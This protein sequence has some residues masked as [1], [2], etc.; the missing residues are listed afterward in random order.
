MNAATEEW[1]VR[2]EDDF[3]VAKREIKVQDEPSFSAVCFHAQQCTEK[4]LKA[5]L[6]ENKIPFVK[7]HD[8]VYLLELMLPLKPLWSVY[9]STL[10]T[11]STYAVDVRYPGEEV[12]KEEALKAVAL[13]AEIRELIRG[14]V[15]M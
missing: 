9:R 13:A 4:Y 3:R 6:Q 14:E 12:S 2:A 1:I 5:F 7:T 8:L 15:T 10:E 11:I